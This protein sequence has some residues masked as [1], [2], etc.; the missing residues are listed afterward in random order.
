MSNPTLSDFCVSVIGRAD[1]EGLKKQRRCGRL[2][3]TSQLA[4]WQLAWHLQLSLSQTKKIDRPCFFTVCIRIVNQNQA[5]LSHF[6]QREISVLSEL[7]LDT[8]VIVE[9]MRARAWL[10]L[11]R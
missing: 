2:P 3:A 1:V 9:Q 11:P 10:S 8:S 4:L 5:S 7:S 6:G